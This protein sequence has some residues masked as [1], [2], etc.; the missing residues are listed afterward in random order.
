[1]S[2][3]EDM[4]VPNYSEAQQD[5][6]DQTVIASYMAQLFLRKHLNS[7]HNTLYRPKTGMF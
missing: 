7:L 4:P 1:M 6:F 3:E 5:G 2:L